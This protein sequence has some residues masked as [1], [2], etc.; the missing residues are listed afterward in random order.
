MNAFSKRAYRG[1][2]AI[3]LGFA[4]YSDPRWATFSQIKQHGGNVKRGEKSTPIVFWAFVD[5]EDNKTGEKKRVPFLKYF[6][7]FNVE[8]TEGLSLKPIADLI[9]CDHSPIEAAEAI[10]K[11]YVSGPKIEY[12]HSAAWYRPSTD[13]VGMPNKE[14]FDSLESFYAVSFHEL[15]HSSGHASRL[16]RPELMNSTHFGS[17]DYS[18]EELTAEFTAYFLCNAAGIANTS[19]EKNTTAYLQNWI[20]VLRGDI[21][22]AVQAAGKAQQAANYILGIKQEDAEE[23]SEVAVVDAIAA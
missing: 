11:G 12:G 5:A 3:V 13:T 7:V 21:K 9:R 18:K 1:I 17:G 23:P 8:Q 19:L 2:N 22:M 10:V 4:R 16:N 20:S 6:S 15:A 14:K